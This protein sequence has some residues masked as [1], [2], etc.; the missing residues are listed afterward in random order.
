VKCPASHRSL[1]LERPLAHESGESPL[2]RFADEIRVAGSGDFLVG[3]RKH[4]D[5]QTVE[6][7]GLFRGLTLSM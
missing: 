4:F 1:P 3:L 5:H 7:T 6:H 2:R